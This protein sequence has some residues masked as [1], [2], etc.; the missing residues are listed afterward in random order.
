[1][2]EKSWREFTFLHQPLINL[3]IDITLSRYKS[4]L[5]YLMELGF[6]D[7]VL[8]KDIFQKSHYLFQSPK[9]RDIFDFQEFTAPFFFFD[10]ERAS[11][12]NV[13]Q[14][15]PFEYVSSFGIPLL[16]KQ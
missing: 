15:L 16:D 4:D 12:G 2:E 7:I 13:P 1:M 3:T 5:L 8:E 6:H 9:L 10:S 11:F 14:R